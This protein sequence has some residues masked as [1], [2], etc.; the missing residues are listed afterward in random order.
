MTYKKLLGKSKAARCISP[1]MSKLSQKILARV[2][3]LTSVS[4]AGVKRTVGASFSYL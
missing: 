2:V 1:G 3:F 4:C